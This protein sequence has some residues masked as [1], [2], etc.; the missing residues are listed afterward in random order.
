VTSA[1]VSV[2]AAEIMDAIQI[3]RGSSTPHDKISRQMK[4]VVQEPMLKR[5]AEVH[6]LLGDASKAREKL[7]WLPKTRFPELVQM[8]VEA[9]LARYR[10]QQ[11]P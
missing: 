6:R 4:G 11:R 8:M 10:A 2:L 3:D 5:P 7:G 1:I 9:D